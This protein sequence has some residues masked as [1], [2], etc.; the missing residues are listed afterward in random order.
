MRGRVMGATVVQRSSR[1][2][3][4]Q[5]S[6]VDQLLVLGP[7]DPPGGRSALRHVL[8]ALPKRLRPTCDVDVVV[9]G[10]HGVAPLVWVGEARQLV[11]L[12]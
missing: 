12:F 6:V 7:R 11:P 10:D 4:F 3:Y 1:V 9:Q 5:V 2:T 8:S